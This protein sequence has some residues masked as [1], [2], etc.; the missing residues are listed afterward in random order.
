MLGKLQPV[1]AIRDRDALPEKGNTRSVQRF[2]RIQVGQFEN[3]NNRVGHLIRVRTRPASSR[4]LAGVQKF[5]HE[6]KR[7]RRSHAR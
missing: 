2:D 7:G 6:T 3:A 1:H 5:E 4:N